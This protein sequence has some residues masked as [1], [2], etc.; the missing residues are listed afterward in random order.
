MLIPEVYRGELVIVDC[1]CLPK[2]IGAMSRF[3]QAKPDTVHVTYYCLHGPIDNFDSNCSRAFKS[4]RPHKIQDYINVSFD[5]VHVVT[6]RRLWFSL[7]WYSCLSKVKSLIF[8]TKE[9]NIRYYTCRQAW[10][11]PRNM[12]A[13]NISGME[14]YW[15]MPKVDNKVVQNVFDKVYSFMSLW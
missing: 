9:S 15:I 11:N 13:R 1:Q 3:F 2:D 12:Q 6:N 7:E 8:W 4:S 5:F 14:N 10:W